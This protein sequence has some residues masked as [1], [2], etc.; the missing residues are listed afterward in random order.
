MNFLR[1]CLIVLAA[2]ILLALSTL[3]SSGIIASAHV[4]EP[5]TGE[6]LD[7]VVLAYNSVHENLEDTLL[8]GSMEENLNH[9]SKAQTKFINVG[10]GDHLW[11]WE[12]DGQEPFR[13]WMY[14]HRRVLNELVEEYKRR[15][16]KDFIVMMADALDVYVTKSKQGNSLDQLKKRFLSSVANEGHKIVFSS[17]IYCCNPWELHEVARRDFDNFYSASGAPPTLYKHL[18][19]GLLMGY[20]SGIIEMAT[21]MGT[22]CVDSIFINSLFADDSY[23]I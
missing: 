18:N 21:E 15:N 9:S 3:Y 14:R 4:D 2:L 6:D 10:M 13:G 23:A 11:Q 7:L 5:S 8:Y 22:W 20:A 1:A 17:Q 12:T 19:A 16:E